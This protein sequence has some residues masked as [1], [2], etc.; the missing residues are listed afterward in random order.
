MSDT[1]SIVE[2][3]DEAILETTGGKPPEYDL[4]GLFEECQ[5]YQKSI[6]GGGEANIEETTW[7]EGVK[8][9]EAEIENRRKKLIEETDEVEEL[10]DSAEETNEAAEPDNPA[11]E[12]NEAAEPD[13]LARDGIIIRR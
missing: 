1:K 4:Q 11:E 3:M 2:E 8:S 12:A 9:R 5:T 10:D 13:N 6:Y 7:L